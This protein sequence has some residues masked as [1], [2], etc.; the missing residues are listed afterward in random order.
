MFSISSVT[1]HRENAQ[2]RPCMSAKPC[3]MLLQATWKTLQYQHPGCDVSMFHQGQTPPWW[4]AGPP[5]CS[6]LAIAQDCVFSSKSASSL[7]PAAPLHLG[8]PAWST[9]RSSPLQS[10]VLNMRAACSQPGHTSVWYCVWCVWTVGAC[11]E[12]MWHIKKE[13]K[14]RMKLL[15]V[16]LE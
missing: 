7:L 2:R 1:L 10:Q 5:V 15:P 11:S 6:G 13:G 8:L 3:E 4:L 16:N 9:A 14:Q 12:A